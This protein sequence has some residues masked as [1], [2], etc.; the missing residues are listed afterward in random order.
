[1][2]LQK[3]DKLGGDKE[4]EKIVKQNK[5]KVRNKELGEMG[6]KKQGYGLGLVEDFRLGAAAQAREFSADVFPREAHGGIVVPGLLT[7]LSVC[8]VPSSQKRNCH[9]SPNDKQKRISFGDTLF[10]RNTQ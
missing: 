4:K 1:M 2:G 8:C 7:A 9:C 10:L 3:E 5:R 6:K